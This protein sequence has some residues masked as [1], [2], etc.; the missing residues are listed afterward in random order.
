MPQDVLFLIVILSH[1]LP[2]VDAPLF[3]TFLV[4]HRIYNLLPPSFLIFHLW[5]PKIYSRRAEQAIPILVIFRR[6][7]TPPVAH[8]VESQR[9]NGRGCGAS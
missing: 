6:R 5:C 8:N 3:S 7:N 2:I 1:L 4:T 9:Y